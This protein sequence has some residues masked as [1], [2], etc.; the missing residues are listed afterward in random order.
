MIIIGRGQSAAVSNQMPTQ[1][2]TILA[3][4]LLRREISGP[5]LAEGLEIVKVEVRP[6]QDISHDLR[7]GQLT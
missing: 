2:E 6:P 1:E 7:A 5:P 3:M 4:A